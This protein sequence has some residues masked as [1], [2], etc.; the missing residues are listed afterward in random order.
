[1]QAMQS[2]VEERRKAYEEVG[3]PVLLWPTPHCFPG[4]RRRGSSG[5]RPKVSNAVPSSPPRTRTL[6]VVLEETAL[7]EDSGFLRAQMEQLLRVSSCPR[8][9]PLRGNDD[10]ATKRS[11]RFVVRAR[12]NSGSNASILGFDRR[13]AGT[14]SRRWRSYDGG[15]PGRRGRSFR[16][17]PVG[18]GA[19]ITVRLQHGAQG[20][21]H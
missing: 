2:I 5:T 13:N 3:L 14:C 6:Q 10:L 12:A 19:C 18:G 9:D 17:A 1:M 4:R 15:L 20:S 8:A 7:E 11:P 16:V 21:T